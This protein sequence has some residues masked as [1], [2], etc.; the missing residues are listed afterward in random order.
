MNSV[1][2]YSTCGD[3]FADTNEDCDCGFEE[4]CKNF[5]KIGECCNQKSC[6][7]KHKDYQCSFGECCNNC[8]YE[9]NKVCRT[10]TK[11]YDGV[12][13]C[14]GDSHNCVELVNKII[15]NTCPKIQNIKSPFKKFICKTPN[16]C[17][18]FICALPFNKKAYGPF[19]FRAGIHNC[20][21]KIY[22]LTTRIAKKAERYGI[23]GN[24]PACMPSAG[25]SDD[26]DS[27]CYFNHCNTLDKL[28]DWRKNQCNLTKANS[29][30]DP[31]PEYKIS[32]ND[33]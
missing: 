31:L 6:K 15:R 23:K 30:L 2:L 26:N 19:Q 21:F 17:C 9:S 8:K 11:E 14:S 5:K 28:E 3:G 12:E 33:L 7:F 10:N 1:R 18:H 22:F 13:Y 25:A 16:L 4:L 20:M 32:F 24:D 27:V 29:K